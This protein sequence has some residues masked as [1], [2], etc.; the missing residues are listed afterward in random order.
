MSLD[1]NNPPAWFLGFFAEVCGLY[2]GWKPTEQTIAA[3]WRHLHDLTADDLA[4]ALVEHSS[5]S[6]YAPSVAELRMCAKPATSIA[7]TAAEAWDQ[8]R[9]NRKLYSPYASQDQNARIQ[10]SSEAVLRASE[11]VGWTDLTWTQEQLPTIRAQFERY[12]NA[13]KDKTSAIDAKSDAAQLVRTISGMVG[14]NGLKQLYGSDYRDPTPEKTHAEEWREAADL[15]ELPDDG[16][17]D[18]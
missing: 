6:K 8:M 16:V 10:W 14:L 4:R 2:P 11:A 17:G 5:S 1:A 3:Y 7:L 13:I 18:G 15:E 9:R 12:Y